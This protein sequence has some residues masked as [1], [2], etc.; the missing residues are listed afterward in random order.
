MSP[1]GFDDIFNASNFSFLEHA[2]KS[3]LSHWLDAVQQLLLP[4]QQH[5]QDLAPGPSVLQGA[6][7]RT[8]EDQQ[9]RRK[10]FR[11]EVS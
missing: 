8:G 10:R 5:H 6:G 3:S 1:S 2:L 7:R 11:T 4:G 9:L